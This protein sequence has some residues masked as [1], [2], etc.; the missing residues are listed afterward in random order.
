MTQFQTFL[1]ASL[2]FLSFIGLIYAIKIH[3]DGIDLEDIDLKKLESISRI[4]S[5]IDMVTIPMSPPRLATPFPTLQRVMRKYWQ[6]KALSNEGVDDGDYGER[7]DS[8][9]EIR[10][11]SV[12]LFRQITSPSITKIPII[13]MTQNRP[14]QVTT[15]IPFQTTTRQ[16]L[17]IKS[18]IPIMQ[19]YSDEKPVDIK[20]LPSALGQFIPLAPIAHEAPSRLQG[21]P[22]LR[23]VLR[24]HL[25]RGSSG[26]SDQVEYVPYRYVALSQS[27]SP[28]VTRQPPL[29]P[30]SILDQ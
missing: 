19:T 7:R 11:K 20:V 28:P 15:D 5:Q 26:K 9:F 21:T 8:S 17:R 16:F 4:A 12:S 14:L 30:P 27:I 22:V 6:P 25:V 24:A 1:S 29:G 18:V 2:Y 23:T 3:S 10:Q 13:L